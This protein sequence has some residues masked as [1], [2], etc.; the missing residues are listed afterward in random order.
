MSRYEIHGIDPHHQVALGWDPPL[1][2][3]FLQVF[4]DRVENEDEQCVLWLGADPGV[5][6]TAADLFA[7]VVPYA[8]LSHDI[9]RRLLADHASDP[10]TRG[11]RST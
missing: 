2:T 8:N 3:Y 6:L 9:V 4:D 11:Q 7:A 10:R 1:Q 5:H